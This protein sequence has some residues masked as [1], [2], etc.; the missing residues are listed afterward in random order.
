MSEAPAP[1]AFLENYRIDRLLGR[2]GFGSVYLAT[3]NTTG[4]QVAIKEI[5]RGVAGE[6][7]P[8]SEWAIQKRFDCPYIVNIYDTCTEPSRYLL[9]MEYVNGGELFDAIVN[10]GAFSENSAAALVQQ[11]LIGLKVL[12]ENHVVH[13]DLKPENLLLAFDSSGGFTCKICDFGLAGM[14]SAHRMNSY[15]GTTGWAA[16][17]MMRNVPYDASVDIWSLGCIL[18]ALLT[19]TRPFDTDDEVELY[20]MVT[21]GAV[22][23]DREEFGDVSESAKDLIRKMLTVDPQKRITIDQALQHPWVRGHAPQV[24]L[25]NLHQHLKIYN[26]K[27]KIK[28]VMEVAR[29]AAK[30]ALLAE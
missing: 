8:E 3:D 4:R 27:R 12:H 16:P 17:E 25:D 5:P 23:Y 21:T 22:D 13:R 9:I 6:L 30:F 10:Y 2:G 18:Y 14:F 11:V 29:A 28:R 24:K 7:T 26:V 1:S 19:A 20:E 15:C